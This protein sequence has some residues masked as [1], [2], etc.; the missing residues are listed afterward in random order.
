MSRRRYAMRPDPETGELVLVELGADYVGQRRDEGRRSEEEIY[1]KTTA[2]DGT[3]LSTRKRHRDYMKSKGLAMTSDYTNSWAKAA[4]E[5]A[6]YFTGQHDSKA[7]RETV[8]K[9]MYQV[10][11][12]RRG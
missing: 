7:I 9:A 5:R 3:D 6:K 11:N 2:P 10:T 12:K 8:E 1:G 4:D